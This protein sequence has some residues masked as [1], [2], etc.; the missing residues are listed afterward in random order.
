MSHRTFPITEVLL[1]TFCHVTEDLDKV[2]KAMLFFIP[3]SFRSKIVLYKDFLEGHYGN[4]ILNLKIYVSD[5]ELIRGIVEFICRNIC[6]ADKK[7][8][9]KTFDSRLDNSGR[10]YLR[11]DK[12]A[13]YH[14][15][16]RL[17]DGSDVIRVILKF[18]VAKKLTKN[19]C[20][21]IGLIM[22]V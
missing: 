4:T 20:F 21:N 18:K 9:F 12:G 13:A 22:D 17:N 6:D 15:F 11:F 8:L 10:L 14:S 16:L 19:V 2:C 3:E 7:L 1:N 5:E